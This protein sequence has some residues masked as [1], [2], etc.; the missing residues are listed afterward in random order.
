MEETRHAGRQERGEPQAVP[1]QP[2]PPNVQA[3]ADASDFTQ[4]S[5]AGAE[6]R[7]ERRS[8][9]YSRRSRRHRDH[10]GDTRLSSR[11]RN[12][13]SRI[14]GR[15]R[16]RGDDNEQSADADEHRRDGPS[17]SGKPFRFFPFFGQSW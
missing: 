5:Q 8:R 3:N 12:D 16:E 7:A 17:R 9:D 13:D 14:W 15:Y 11:D 1:V 2:A 6:P 10:G 4:S